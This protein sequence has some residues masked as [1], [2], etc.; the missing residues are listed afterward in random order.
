MVN[1]ILDNNNEIEQND[2]ELDEAIRVPN[3]VMFDLS[4]VVVTVHVA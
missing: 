3:Q 1:F 2:S 4:R